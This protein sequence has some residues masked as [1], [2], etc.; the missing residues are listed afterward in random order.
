[1]QVPFI[2][3]QLEQIQLRGGTHPFVNRPLVILAD[4]D[5]DELDSLV[6]NCLVAWMSHRWQVDNCSSN[7]LRCIS[8]LRTLWNKRMWLLLASV[9]EV[10][11]CVDCCLHA[12][13][14]ALEAWAAGG[15]HPLW[16]AL[17][18]STG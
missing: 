11:A 4:K 18:V 15:A 5:K 9:C 17:Q 7:K 6:S 16:Q 12:G 14:G 3:D 13:A 2:L 10:V 8:C 1:M